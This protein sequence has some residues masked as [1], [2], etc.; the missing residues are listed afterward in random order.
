VDWTS[1][2]HFIRPWWLL[3]LVPV[4]V[5]LWRLRAADDDVSQWQ[6]SVDPELLEHLLMGD[7]GDTR[8]V[9]WHVLLAVACNL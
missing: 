6:Q 2:F 8:S 3:A 4:A 1:T 7:T 5:L 9:L